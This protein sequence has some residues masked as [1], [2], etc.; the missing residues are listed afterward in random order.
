M[1][2][3]GP[4]SGLRLSEPLQADCSLFPRASTKRRLPLNELCG[5]TR[6]EAMGALRSPCLSSSPLWAGV[7]ALLED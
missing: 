7:L 1:V 6:H 3:G 2:P 5:C 4:D